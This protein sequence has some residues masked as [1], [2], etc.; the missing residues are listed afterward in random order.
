MSIPAQTPLPAI[1]IGRGI[2]G[3]SCAYRLQRAGISVRVLDAASHPGGVIS[4]I[5]KDGFLFELGP[6]SFLS[7]QP[8]LELIASL[9]IDD[10]LLHADARAPRYVL[11]HGRLVAAPLAPQSLLTT[12]LLGARTK[13]RLLTEMFHHTRPPAGD[14]SIASFVRRKF[15]DELLDRLVAPFVSGVYAGDP[16]K[17]SLRA[18]FPKL[19]EFEAS[20]GSVLRGAM[21]SRPPKGTPRPGLCTFRRGMATLPRTLGMRLG[22]A[23]LSETSVV[24][25]R[26]AEANGKRVFEVAVTRGGQYGTLFASAVIVATPTNAASQMLKGLWDK[27]EETFSRVEYAPIAVVSAGYRR[28]QIRESTNGFGFLVPRGEGL[29]VLGTVWNSSLFPGRAPEGMACFTSFAGGA[30]DAE[31][32]QSSDA[33]ITNIVCGE[34]GRV[35]RIEGEPVITSIHRYPRALP[36]YNLGHSEIVSA[37]GALTSSVPGL[38]LTGNYLTGPSI[39]SCVEQAHH[40]ADA[41]S[42]YLASIGVL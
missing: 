29:R 36:Q 9:G 22:D 16:E 33:Q 1:V 42:G 17:L 37:L 12:P 14:E 3:L 6:Q 39:G 40:I 8:L 30:T 4:T 34:V 25:V 26:Q 13:W 2:S 18:S 11:L 21:K 23:F 7:S 28:E 10:E 20:Y 32:C 19:H 15:G 5:E 31:L 41:A 24:E 38:F 27:C 35:L